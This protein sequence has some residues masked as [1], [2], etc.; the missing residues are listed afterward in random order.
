MSLT[1]IAKPLL[2]GRPLVRILLT[3]LVLANLSS[4][5]GAE[6]SK[7]LAPQG[8][9]CPVPP[10]SA[11]DSHSADQPTDP[12]TGTDQDTV[13]PRALIAWLLDEHLVRDGALDADGDGN[14]LIGE[15]FRALTEAD[16]C[17]S[18]AKA[19]FGR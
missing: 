2:K 7:P 12:R 16:Y 9:L 6:D 18:I 13:P 11:D 8:Q 19:W 10:R 17:S 15:K 4:V 14:T 3:L 5:S 1:V